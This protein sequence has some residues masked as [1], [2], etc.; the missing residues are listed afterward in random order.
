M[1]YQDQGS[2]GAGF[3]LGFF[4]GLVGLIIA[5]AID[6]PETRRG[7]ATGFIVSLIISAVAA[8]CII[9]GAL[10]GISNL[11]FTAIA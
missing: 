11:A 7:A 3:A 2:Y 8:G 5:I 9:C 10:N 4:L 6:K 1:D